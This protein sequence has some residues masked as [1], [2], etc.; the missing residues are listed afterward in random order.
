M[1]SPDRISEDQLLLDRSR[2]T[3]WYGI[4]C[5]ERSKDGNYKG[6]FLEGRVDFL[7]RVGG[8]A[9]GEELVR[10]FPLE[11]ESLPDGRTI[12]FPTRKASSVFDDLFG[13]ERLA[14]RVVNAIIAIDYPS[15]ILV[16]SPC[17]SK[18]WIER[19]YQTP[20]L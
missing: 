6:R 9:E 2:S 17:N 11:N 7:V 19:G 13:K 3:L 1:A 12:Y 5:G 15:Q 14:I 10:D 20:P 16:V 8:L 4:I 18:R